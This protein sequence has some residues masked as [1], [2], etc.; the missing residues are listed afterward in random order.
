MIPQY[1]K[2][3]IDSECLISRA[4]IRVEH[5]CF[6]MSNARNIINDYKSRQKNNLHTVFHVANSYD[7]VIYKDSYIT[8]K[9]AA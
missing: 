1:Y 2:I 4:R 3:I 8:R 6:G 7:K 9:R 5:E